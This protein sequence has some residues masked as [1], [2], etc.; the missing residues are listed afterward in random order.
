MIR[1]STRT[2]DRSAA[3]LFVAK[4]ARLFRGP[5]RGVNGAVDEQQRQREIVGDAFGCAC[6]RR[7]ESACCRHRPYAALDLCCLREDD[8][9]RAGLEFRR[10]QQIEIDCADVTSRAGPPDEIAPKDIGMQRSDEESD[11]PE[12]QAG[13][14]SVAFA[15]SAI[16]SVRTGADLAPSISQSVIFL[17]VRSVHGRQCCRATRSRRPA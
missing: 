16:M 14:T 11:P 15:G 10:I 4:A 12:R 13:R 5:A 2:S 9:E 7:S 6:R 3:Q 17:Q 8:R 1:A